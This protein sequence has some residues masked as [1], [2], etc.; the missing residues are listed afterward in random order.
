MRNLLTLLLTVSIVQFSNAQQTFPVNGVNDERHLLYAFRNAT[1]YIDYKT[2]IDS[3]TLI[4]RDG[5][6]WGAGK[7]INIPQGAVVYDL[8]GKY[9]YPS[10]ID[11]FSDYGINIEKPDKKQDRRGHQFISNT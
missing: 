11:L 6:V 10:F 8:S 1:I 2:V 9:I 3:A 7:G 4:V 5:K